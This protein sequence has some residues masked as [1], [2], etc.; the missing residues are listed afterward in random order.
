MPR[1]KQT[2]LAGP[3]NALLTRT[4][5]A[6]QSPSPQSNPLVLTGL[7]GAGKSLLLELLVEEFQRSFD[8]ARVLLTTAVD[9][10]RAYAHAVET[11]AI[12]EFRQ[13]YS[14]LH[15]LALDDVHRLAG[16]PAAQQEL[17]RLI[18]SLVSRGCQV[19]ATLRWHPL[20]S[21]ALTSA[22]ASRLS[23]GLVAPIL[24]P[25]ELVRTALIQYFASQ[26]EVELP[27]PAAQ[28]LIAQAA[29]RPR[30]ATARQLRSAVMALAELARQRGQDID[31]HLVDDYLQATDADTKT[32]IKTTAGAVGKHLG[33]SVGDL[34][35]KSR[36]KSVS[37][38]RSLAMHLARTLTGASYAEIGRYFGDRDHT[39]VMHACR[40]TVAA[41]ADDPQVQRL[42]DELSLRLAAEETSS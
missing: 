21:A 18:D 27:P 24:L 28:S 9:F 39:T 4:L 22:L 38:A 2:F 7:G 26:L 30:L 10:A 29:V 17:T 36:Q 13:R 8:H 40:K 1:R 19:L 42:V 16:K 41:A 11:D 33:I 6:V 31:H 14:R 35:G 25:G 20:E 23:A 3:E 32:A 12:G 5:S 37:A 15:L 34:R